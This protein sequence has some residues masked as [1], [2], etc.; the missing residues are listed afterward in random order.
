MLKSLDAEGMFD[1]DSGLLTRDSFWRDLNNVVIEACDRSLPLTV[2]RFS[3]NDTSDDRATIDAARLMTRLIRNVD[4]ATRDDEGAIL[5]AFTQTDLR[6]AHVV[7]RRIAGTLRNTMLTPQRAAEP[8]AANVAL[9]TLKA[10]DTLG[11]L[12]M[13]LAGGRMVAAE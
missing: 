2:A 4:F 13:R 10:G 8:L 3:F 5:V 7:A 9:A 11:T 12:M 1:P 6:S